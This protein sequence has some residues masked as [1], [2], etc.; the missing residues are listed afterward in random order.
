VIGKVGEFQEGVSVAAS[1]DPAPVAPNAQFAFGN[2]VMKYLVFHDPGWDYS[3][4]SFDTFFSDVAAASQT[5]DAVDPNL[6]AFRA[7]GGKL[8]MTNGWGDM[9]ISPYGTIAYYD[10]VIEHDPTAVNDV[11]L[12]ILPGVEHCQGGVGPYWVNYIDVIDA[13]VESGDAPQQLTAFWLDEQGQ[14]DGSRPVCAYP[15]YPVY[16]GSGDPRDA[17]NF[18]CVGGP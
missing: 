4:Y 7:R 9:A 2:G 8:L 10:R 13:W 16:D 11:R 3:T 15:Q 6:D 18:S 14:P 1:D 5:L 17:S 12:M